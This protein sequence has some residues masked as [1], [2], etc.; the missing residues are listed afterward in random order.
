MKKAGFGVQKKRGRLDKKEEK[1]KARE[2]KKIKKG[3]VTGF[4]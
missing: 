2:S 3:Q 1:G 4:R